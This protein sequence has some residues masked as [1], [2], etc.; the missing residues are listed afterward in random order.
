MSIGYVP[1]SCHSTELSPGS[2]YVV[3][4]DVT[5]TGPAG[6]LQV[7]PVDTEIVATSSNLDE[8]LRACRLAP[9]YPHGT[10]RRAGVA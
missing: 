1:G 2:D 9:L 4:A 6:R 3:I 5:E 7:R 8:V 10:W